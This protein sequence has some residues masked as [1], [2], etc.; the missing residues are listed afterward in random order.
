MPLVFS[1]LKPVRTLLFLLSCLA[2]F[3]RAEAQGSRGLHI[4]YV[5]NMGVALVKGDTALLIDALHDL[6]KPGYLPSS[7]SFLEGLLGKQRRY[8]VVPAIVISHQ[9]NDHFDAALVHKAVAAYPHTRVLTGLQL[10]PLLHAGQSGHYRLATDTVFAPLMPNLSVRLKR[11]PHTYQSRNGSIH[12]YR[13]EV[14]WNGMR[15]VHLGDALMSEATLRGLK[16]VDVLIAP[17]W[18]FMERESVESIERLRPKLV[19]LTHV[20]PGAEG[21][22]YQS[23]SI[24]PVIFTAYGQKV[25]L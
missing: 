21:A 14:V 10:K 5:G 13:A 11:I 12:N 19:I 2:V 18:L 20:S 22:T 24:K 9:H 25:S 1:L 3:P 7:P 23:S 6:Y 16:D 15:I 8:Q 17:N 4:E